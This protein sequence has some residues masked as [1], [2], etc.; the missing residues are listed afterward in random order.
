MLRSGGTLRTVGRF[1]W[2]AITPPLGVAGIAGSYLALGTGNALGLAGVAAVLAMVTGWTLHSEHPGPRQVPSLPVIGLLGAAV[3]L[4]VVGLLAE[5][6]LVGVATIVAV[7]GTG[8]FVV[9]RHGQADEASGSDCP[10]RS[11]EPGPTGPVLEQLPLDPLPP[12][13]SVHTLSTAELCRIWQLTFPRLCRATSPAETEHL[14]E[15][16]CRC[17]AQLEGRDPA[18]FARWLPTARAAGDPARYFCRPTPR[19][20]GEVSS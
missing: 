8:R 11:E 3:G 18:A 5:T 12:L 9:R 1:L 17:L 4:A 16:R 2:W 6:G 7:A 10:E 20:T 14:T 13:A 19:A 15:L